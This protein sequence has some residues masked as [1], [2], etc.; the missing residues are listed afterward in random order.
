[1]SDDILSRT[2]PAADARL[3][4]GSDPNQFL[5][6]RMPP[7]GSGAGRPYPLVI[8][9][10]G[11]FWRAKYNLDHNG[12]LCGA[13]TAKGLAT[14]NLEYRRVGNDGGAWPGTF[15]D[16]R[17]AYRYL[18]Q[19]AGAQ[20]FTTDKVIVVGHSAGGQLALCLAAHEGGIAGVVSLAGVVDLQRAY[21]LHLSND[22][23]V[24]FL[25]GTPAEVPD[26]YREADPMRLAIPHARQWLIHGQDDDTVPTAFSRN[27]VAEKQ[28]RSGSQ[29]EDARLLEIAGAG[30]FDL[31]D[32][33]SIAWKQVEETVLRLAI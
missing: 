28:T 32:P 30:H 33:K 17:A 7:E 27:Y 1:M 18:K 25:R 12:H 16:L 14:A 23:V 31:I 10:H 8:N 13:L 29:K 26:H 2:P 6:L 3:A 5:D 9:I 4:Y 19:N 20:G 15:E 11:G 24:E 21:Q 22:A